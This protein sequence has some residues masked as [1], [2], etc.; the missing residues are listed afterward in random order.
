MRVLMT[1]ATTHMISIFF[2]KS[3]TIEFDS[4]LLRTFMTNKDDFN[5]SRDQFEDDYKFKFDTVKTL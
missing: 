5:V 1:T 3:I 2:I 4:S